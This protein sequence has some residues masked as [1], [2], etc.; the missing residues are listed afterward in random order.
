MPATLLAKDP[1]D[2][3]LRAY[4]EFQAGERSER[5][6]QVRD[7]LNRYAMAAKTLE[8][9]QRTDPDWQSLVVDYRL[10]KTQENLD[11]LRTSV[12]EAQLTAIEIEDPLPT[13]GFEIDIPEP[14]VTTRPPSGE[15]AAPPAARKNEESVRVQ[16][17]L[18]E[19][20]RQIESLK[21]DLEKT[22]GDLTGAKAEIDRTK[23]SLVEVRSQLVQAQAN[24]ENVAAER[25]RMK[26]KNTGT[27]D[28][29]T[30]EL[31]DRIERLEAENEVLNDENKRLSDKLGKAGNYIEQS[32]EVLAATEKDRKALAA[33]RDKARA[34]LA[35]IKDNQSEID[36]LL[37]ERSEIEKK[38]AE[39]KGALEKQIADQK[40]AL[41]LVAKL[42]AENKNLSARLEKAESALQDPAKVQADQKLRDSLQEEI[43]LLKDRL[44]AARGELQARDESIKNLYTQLD[45]ASGEA[46]RLRL[47]PKPTDEQKRVADENELLKNIVLRQLKD[48]NE[49][50]QAVSVLEQELENLYVKSDTLSTQ[51]AVLSKP[52]SKFSDQEILIFRDPL[53]VLN[54]PGEVDL[55]VSMT[56]SKSSDGS[57]EANNK[58]PEGAEVFSPESRQLVEKAAELVRERRFTDAEKIYQQLT[59]EHPDNPFALSNLAVTQIHAGK[60]A[61]ALVALEKTLRLSPGD[62]FASVNISNV[63]CRQGRFDEAVEVLKEVIKKDPRNAVAYNYLAIALGKQGNTREAEE[64]FQRSILLDDNYPNAHFNLAVMYAN[65]DPPSLELARKHYEI[66]KSLGSEPDAVMERRLGDVTPPR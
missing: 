21:K 7:A 8:T 48:Q 54:D 10:R 37:K 38:F 32:N 35:K 52:P 61:A 34:S 60:H 2:L 20:R 56:I 39:E 16:R 53:V 22:R 41:D 13:G 26:S 58:S 12:T 27:S 3:F 19:A 59:D 42:E 15:M 51:L 31:A 4:Q 64:N 14:M 55:S 46:A 57:V 25:D 5:E 18:T 36:R 28:K 30:M 33:Q 6:G 17:Q 24:L 47:D 49:R 45:E 66:A 63:Y 65:T 9:I 23:S 40:P 50:T 11:R 43:T 62:V 44:S 29:R 1:S